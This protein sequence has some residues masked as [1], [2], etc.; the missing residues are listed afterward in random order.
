MDAIRAVRPKRVALGNLEPFDN[1]PGVP[2]RREYKQSAS[3]IA[4]VVW[5]L[6]G[7]VCHDRSGRILEHDPELKLRATLILQAGGWR[8]DLPAPP[9]SSDDDSSND[10]FGSGVSWQDDWLESNDS[11]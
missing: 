6:A 9:V 10:G 11:W 3:L 4:T 8:S 7:V 1:E 2:L 5:V